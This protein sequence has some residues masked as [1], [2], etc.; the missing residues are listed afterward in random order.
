MTGARVG[1]VGVAGESVGRLS[2]AVSGVGSNG[3]PVRSG[4][5]ADPVGGGVADWGP[6]AP[7]PLAFWGRSANHRIHDRNFRPQ[8]P[9]R[10]PPARTRP[11]FD[12]QRP[13]RFPP[14]LPLVLPP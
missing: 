12:C 9:A 14:F 1:S 11:F 4:S 6:P 7:P 3:E 2:P 5:A 8:P 10:R 13:L